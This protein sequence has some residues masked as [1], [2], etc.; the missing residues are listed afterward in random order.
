ME[1]LLGFIYMLILW[2]FTFGEELSG[3]EEILL[4]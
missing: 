3:L 4:G 2:R 1:H